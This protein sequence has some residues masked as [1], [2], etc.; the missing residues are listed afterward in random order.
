MNPPKKLIIAARQSD[1]A[2]LQAYRVGHELQRVEQGL[3]IEYAFRASLGDKNL[4]DPLWKM[5]EKGVFTEDF[6]GDLIEGRADVTEQ[7]MMHGRVA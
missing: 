1:L 7:I 5:P 4:E 3:E 6:L 2:R